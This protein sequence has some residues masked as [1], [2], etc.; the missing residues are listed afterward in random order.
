M[1]VDN[2]IGQIAEFFA[3]MNGGKIDSAKLYKLIYIAKRQVLTNGGYTIYFEHMSLSNAG[4]ILHKA[5]K[6]IVNA[7]FLN[8]FILHNSENIVYPISKNYNRCSLD[9]LSDFFMDELHDVWKK[10][11]H[12]N[13]SELMYYM[14]NVFLEFAKERSPYLDVDITYLDILK[15]A[16]NPVADAIYAHILEWERIDMFFKGDAINS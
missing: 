10:H 13:A 8:K 1:D 6:R 15:A 3:H 11:G 16:S 5:R 12:Q 4:I 2:I 9:E 7:N 14:N